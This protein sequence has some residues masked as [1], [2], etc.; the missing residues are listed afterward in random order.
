MK[1]PDCVIWALT[2]KHNSNLVKFNGNQWS[3]SALSPRGFHNASSSASTIGV[4]AHQQKTKKHFSRVFSLSL[5]HK[6]NH[7]AK[8]AKSAKSQSRINTSEILL[9]KEVNNAAKTIQG[10]TF[11]NQKAKNGA[12]RRLAK[13][14]AANRSHTEK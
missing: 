12:L 9:T 10:L 3:T 13:Q 14:S 2:R 4:G 7:G 5:K 11:Q 1:T 6:L 8:S